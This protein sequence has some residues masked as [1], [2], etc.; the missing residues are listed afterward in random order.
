MGKIFTDGKIKKYGI[1]SLREAQKAGPLRSR[2]SDVFSQSRGS[3][4]AKGFESA[5]PAWLAQAQ[6]CV[7][8][9][10]S[11]PIRVIRGPQN[12]FAKMERRL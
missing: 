8:L 10:E 12:D 6:P 3:S 4:L 7:S 9:K 5:S 1:D 11:V 2:M